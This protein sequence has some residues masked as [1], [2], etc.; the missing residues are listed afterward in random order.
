LALLFGPS[1]VVI[2]VVSLSI[3][4]CTYRAKPSY[5]VRHHAVSW[6]FH[7]KSA[8]RTQ[9]DRLIMRPPC[10]KHENAIAPTISAPLDL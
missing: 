8:D 5:S 6:R 2:G 9:I 10:D 7:L 4:T 3:L 1:G